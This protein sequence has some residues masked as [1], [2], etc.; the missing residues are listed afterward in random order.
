VVASL[1]VGGWGGSRY[2]SYAVGSERNRT[3]FVNGILDLAKEYELD[4]IDFECVHPSLH[5]AVRL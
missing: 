1:S 4:G 3:S 5:F 2:F